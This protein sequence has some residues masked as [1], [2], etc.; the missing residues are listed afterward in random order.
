MQPEAR[1][2]GNVPVTRTASQLALAA[3]PVS[4][5][6]TEGGHLKKQAMV[7]ACSWNRHGHRMRRDQYR[8]KRDPEKG[9]KDQ[10]RTKVT[11]PSSARPTNPAH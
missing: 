8:L 11:G 1:E 5:G 3:D 7:V 2:R 4:G 9:K 10:D 6:G